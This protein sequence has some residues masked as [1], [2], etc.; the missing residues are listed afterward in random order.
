[1]KAAVLRLGWWK[2]WAE[3]GGG[4]SHF[5]I[6]FIPEDK[7]VFLKFFQVAHLTQGGL[8]AWHV[9]VMQQLKCHQSVCVEHMSCAATM[10]LGSGLAFVV[11]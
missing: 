11:V 3:E 7:G 6:L 9:A 4:Q 2:F 1:M 5:S 8:L 10:S